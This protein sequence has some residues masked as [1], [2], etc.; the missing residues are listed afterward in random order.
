MSGELS[1]FKILTFDVYGTLIDWE[2][3]ITRGLEPIMKQRPTITSDAIL[4]LHAFHESQAQAQTPGKKYSDIL[5][6][7]YRRISEALELPVSWEACLTYGASVKNW[8][9]FG[10]SAEALAYLKKHFKLAVLSNVDHESFAYSQAKLGIDFDAVFT[11]EDVGHYKP[12]LRNFE[13]ML[14]HLKRRGLE[15]KD[16]LHVAESMFHDHAPANGIGLR[17][18]W[19]YRRH[20]KEGFGATRHPG[21]M[22]KYDFRFHALSE[23]VEA[24]RGEQ[25]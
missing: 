25:C 18:A 19:I 13:Y 15:A 5:A 14:E 24:H 12:D 4:E 9:A 8:P 16:V 11:A 7:V 2:T 10:D 3:G 17:N 1:Q 6:L 20:E 21:T 22:P 23:L